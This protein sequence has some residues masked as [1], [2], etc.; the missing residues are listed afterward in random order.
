MTVNVNTDKTNTPHD[1][2]I[3]AENP[4][5]A[6]LKKEHDEAEAEIER[7]GQKGFKKMSDKE[8]EGKR[9]TMKKYRKALAEAFQ[10]AYEKLKEDYEIELFATIQQIPGGPLLPALQ[11]RRW[12]K[13]APQAEMKPWSEA[14]RENLNTRMDCEHKP[15]EIDEYCDLCKLPRDAWGETGKGCSAAYIDRQNTKIA[16]QQEKERTEKETGSA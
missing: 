14:M 10:A 2:P 12:T 8:I 5:L 7:Q 4:I 6:R 13:P 16:A 15:D 9:D 1:P 3:L 11:L